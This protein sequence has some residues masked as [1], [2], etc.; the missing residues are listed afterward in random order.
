MPWDSG[1]MGD[2]PLRGRIQAALS[3]PTTGPSIRRY[4]VNTIFDA[5]FVMLGVIIG[6]AFSENPNI[7]IITVTI[8]TSAVALGISTGVS[9]FEAE[10][11]EQRIRLGEIEKAL[12]RSLE[13]THIGRSSRTS[14]YLIAGLNLLAPIT[15]G[16]LIVAPFLMFSGD[17]V[18]AAWTAVA[19]AL[20]VLFTTGYFMGKQGKRNPWVQGGRMAV[21]GAVAFVVCYLIQTLV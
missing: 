9:V 4:F 21:V 6:S 15:A 7:H 18:M 12:L 16:I 20:L 13:D 14:I 5:T 2:T 1:K 10:S 11:M 3:L 17:I 19:L 8:I